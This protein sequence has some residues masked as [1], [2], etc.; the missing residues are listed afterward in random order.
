MNKYIQQMLNDKIHPKSIMERNTD[1][2]VAFPEGYVGD[3]VLYPHTGNP[4]EDLSN[5]LEALGIDIRYNALKQ[6]AEVC[7]RRFKELKLPQWEAVSNLENGKDWVT[8]Y[9][10]VMCR[11][12]MLL[13]R[14]TGYYK[15]TKDEFKLIMPKV[16]DLNLIHRTEALASKK[17]ICNPF[18]EWVKSLYYKHQ[19]TVVD[20]KD[21]K[22]VAIREFKN[23]LNTCFNFR[24]EKDAEYA[25]LGICCTLVA[26]I[27]RQAPAG[28]KWDIAT[29]LQGEPG[30]GKTSF[31]ENL[32]E[33]GN[34][35][36]VSDVQ[37]VKDNK[38][39]MDNLIGCVMA[40]FSE[41]ETV[42]RFMINPLKSFLSNLVDVYREPY[43]KK[44]QSIIRRFVTVGTTNN[45]Q[46]IP[47]DEGLKRRINVVEVLA[48]LKDPMESGRHVINTMKIR[49]RE[50]LWACAFSLEQ[51]N[52]L[53]ENL[54]KI[55]SIVK[56]NADKYIDIDKQ[57]VDKI[58]DYLLDPEKID[59]MTGEIQ[60]KWKDLED[61]LKDSGMSYFK[62]QQ[63]I[64]YALDREG[65]KKTHTFKGN[66]WVKNTKK[67]DAGSQT[68]F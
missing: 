7:F 4:F 28:F 21:P 50:M 61:C 63:T 10:L 37:L 55:S 33:P 52:W 57:Q 20:D 42:T 49:G 53:E 59:K 38:Q 1:G 60:V 62:K 17:W 18:Y 67:S 8:L 36:F 27:K 25:F 40:D 47:D 26:C 16:P 30:I 15:E 29:I 5:R 12:Q 58:N 56:Q 35:F 44:K 34:E 6:N 14:H 9:D 23:I 66:M 24:S 54:F 31:W 41:Y 39:L 32:F 68:P 48:K 2:P 3:V 65:F 19:S 13:M 64:K 51:T 22:G 45:K 11:I 46:C 43:A